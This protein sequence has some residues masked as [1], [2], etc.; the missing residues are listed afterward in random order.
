MSATELST[1]LQS[2]GGWGLSAI[3]MVVIVFLVKHILKLSDDKDRR[4]TE[5]NQQMLSMI[6]KKIETD[7]KHEQAFNNLAEMIE[8]LTDRL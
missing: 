3:L 5:Q 2:A 6:E 7:I 1:L 4:A 8:K